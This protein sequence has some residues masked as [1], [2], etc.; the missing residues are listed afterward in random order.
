MVPEL[1]DAATT[2]SP[3]GALDSDGTTLGG[4]C[5]TVLASGED[6]YGLDTGL[7]SA[8]ETITCE[9]KF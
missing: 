9:N 3:S 2:A 5:C 7:P 4:A 1:T 8:I 6:T